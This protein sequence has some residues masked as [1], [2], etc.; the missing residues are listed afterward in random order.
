MDKNAKME[1]NYRDL[2]RAGSACTDLLHPDH[3]QSPT[4]HRLNLATA[5]SNAGGGRR[6]GVFVPPLSNKKGKAQCVVVREGRWAKPGNWGGAPD[7]SCIRLLGGV[8]SGKQPRARRGNRR[9]CTEQQSG[10]TH[11]SDTRHTT[12]AHNVFITCCSV[13]KQSERECQQQP[14]RR[15]RV[16]YT[17]RPT[18]VRRRVAR[19]VSLDKVGVVV[20]GGVV[21]GIQAPAARSVWICQNVGKYMHACP[22]MHFYNASAPL[23]LDGDPASRTPPSCRRKII[24]HQRRGKGCATM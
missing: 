1:T 22:L 3:G 24:R 5:P 12:A 15:E 13:P 6:S 20:L 11:T 8:Q 23:G 14:A 17:I 16:S 18:S 21:L 2:L 19:H 9:R 4:F 10:Y 7:S